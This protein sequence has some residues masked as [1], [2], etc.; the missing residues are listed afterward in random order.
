[1]L[2]KIGNAL[3]RVGDDG[4]ERLWMWVEGGAPI[5]PSVD[6]R[7]VLEYGE[8]AFTRALSISRGGERG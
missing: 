5:G 2:G 4:F 1:M 3:R 8:E 6:S 7:L